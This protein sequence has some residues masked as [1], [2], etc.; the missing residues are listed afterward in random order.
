MKTK[1][2]LITHSLSIKI[3]FSATKI[4]EMTVL[5]ILFIFS[6]NFGIIFLI[7]LRRLFRLIYSQHASKSSSFTISLKTSSPIWYFSFFFYIFFST[8]ETNGSY[9]N[10]VNFFSTKLDSDLKSKWIYQFVNSYPY[11]TI[12]I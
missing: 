2:F 8:K 12:L 9:W 1:W 4:S 7:W 11:L 3:S 5:S 10:I 6:T